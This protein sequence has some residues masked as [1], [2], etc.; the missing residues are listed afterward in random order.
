MICQ[1]SLWFCRKIV[2][3]PQPFQIWN[4]C[5]LSFHPVCSF[6]A[7]ELFFYVREKTKAICKG[8][9]CTK[10]T[11]SYV[12]VPGETERHWWYSALPTN[13]RWSL[14]AHALNLGWSW[15]LLSPTEC[16]RSDVVSVVELRLQE[17]LRLYLCPLRALPGNV[18]KG[19]IDCWEG[20]WVKRLYNLRLPTSL[21]LCHTTSPLT[22]DTP[23]T[24]GLLSAPWLPAQGLCTCCPSAPSTWTTLLPPLSRFCFSSL[25]S[26]LKPHLRA[27]LAIHPI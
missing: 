2:F 4:H 11:D 26:Q 17:T 7:G 22:H 25:R 16:G 18:R 27:S 3:N 15:V 24:Q 20:K 5:F 9:N 1:L 8:T 21:S 13:K 10:S 19:E 14:L 23:I 12:S 6:T